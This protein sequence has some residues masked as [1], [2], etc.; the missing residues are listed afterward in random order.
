MV[1][2]VALDVADSARAGI[3]IQSAVLSKGVNEQTGSADRRDP[4]HRVSLGAHWIVDLGDDALHAERLGRELCRKHFPVVAL[5]KREEKIRAVR[6]EAS[7][8]ILLGPVATH[9]L[10][11]EVGLKAAECVTAH[12]HDRHVMSRTGKPL[13]ESC[14]DPAASHNHCSHL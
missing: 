3:R 2:V 11:R 13:G 9:R 14:A 10:A 12:V 1:L 8:H 6:P 7:Q 5:S 4:E